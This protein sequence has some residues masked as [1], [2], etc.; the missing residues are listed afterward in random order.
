MPSDLS[1]GADAAA[2]RTFLG[3]HVRSLPWTDASYCS[4]RPVLNPAFDKPLDL[5]ALVPT[6][7]ASSPPPHLAAISGLVGGH[8][9]GKCLHRRVAVEL[10]GVH[11]A[12]VLFPGWAETKSHPIADASTK[13]WFV[14]MTWWSSFQLESP[15][16]TSVLREW[17]AA[18]W[19]ERERLVKAMRWPC[20]T[21]P[22]RP[23]S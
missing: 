13:L 7:V 20:D 9:Y 17:I 18:L 8:Y 2:M 4:P 21:V 10:P 14:H 19:I 23:G 12:Q 1:L 22:C 15:P 3:D 5:S 6:D 11:G 16:D